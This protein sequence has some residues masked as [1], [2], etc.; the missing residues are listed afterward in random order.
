MSNKKL[1]FPI[2]G[3]C[4]ISPGEIVFVDRSYIYSEPTS[5]EKLARF[6]DDEITAEYLRRTPLGKAFE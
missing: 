3:D 2:V 6:T 1:V 5:E 4:S